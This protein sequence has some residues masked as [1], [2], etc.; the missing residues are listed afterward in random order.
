MLRPPMLDD[1]TAQLDQTHLGWRTLPADGG[2]EQDQLIL[3][4]TSHEDNQASDHAPI[5]RFNQTAAASGEVEDSSCEGPSFL[6]NQSEAKDITAS[7]LEPSEEEHCP[8]V[9]F[10]QT[11]E[12]SSS[13]TI[14]S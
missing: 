11:A 12:N 4:A 8:L 9:V 7:I 13:A 1:S 14:F 6:W 3:G 10:N 5:L 2:A